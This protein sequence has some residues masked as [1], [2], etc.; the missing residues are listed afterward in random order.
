MEFGPVP[1]NTAA[2]AILAHSIRLPGRALKKGHLLTSDD[3]AALQQAG[4]ETVTVCR[5]DAQD[6]AEDAAADS[7]AKAATGHGL[8]RSSAFTGRVNLIAQQD[9]ILVYDAAQ[10]DSLNRVDEGITL[11]PCPPIVGF[12][13]VRWSPRPRLFPLACPMRR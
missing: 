3:A 5:L 7:L 11:R 9:G 12:L 13:H 4:I 1:S 10:L 2:G 6:V 8:S